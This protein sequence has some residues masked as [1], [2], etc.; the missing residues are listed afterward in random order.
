MKKLIWLIVP[1]CIMAMQCEKDNLESGPGP[2][3]T[4]LYLLTGIWVFEDIIDEIYHYQRTEELGEGYG[5]IIYEDGR[6]VERKNAGWCGT[7]PISY[8]DFEGNWTKQSDSVLRINVDFWGGEDIY[9]LII[10]DVT[11]NTLQ[12]I[13]NNIETVF[14]E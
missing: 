10:V 4:T 3:G 1:L 8:A 12:T 11:E 6:F 14:S 5:F 9:E 13:R 7:P 2:D